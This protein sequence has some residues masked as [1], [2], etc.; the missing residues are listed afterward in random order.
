MHFDSKAYGVAVESILALEGDGARLLELAS[1]VCSPEA[2]RTL[3]S[4]KSAPDLFPDAAHPAEALAGLWIYFGCFD[5]AHQVT[6]DLHSAEGSYWHAIL[7]RQEPDPSNAIYWFHRVGRHAIFTELQIAANHILA[8]HP[9]A[10]FTLKSEWDPKAFIEFCES[11]RG[12]P[13]SSGEKAAKQ[14]QLAE[15]QLLF[16]H[17]ARRPE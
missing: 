6:Q 7:H 2:A 17:C 15:W 4:T 1:P 5:E 16:H 12:K 10:G 8:S 3:L 9:D 11:V 13:G 14:I